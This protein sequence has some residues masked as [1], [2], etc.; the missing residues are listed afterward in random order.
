MLM[1]EVCPTGLTTCHSCTAPVLKGTLRFKLVSEVRF[2]KTVYYHLTCWKPRNL[3][4]LSADSFWYKDEKAKERVG[5]VVAWVKDWNEQFITKEETV[6]AQFLQKTV[7]TTGTPLRRL[8]LEVFQWLNTSEIETIVAVCCKAWYHVS[9]EEEFWRTR[10]VAELHPTE[11]ATEGD[12]RRKYIAYVKG[13]C[14]HCKSFLTLHEVYMRCPFF[15]RNL[16]K[17]CSNTPECQITSLNRYS[18]RQNVSMELLKELNIPTF[19]FRSK[20]GNYMLVIAA[21]VVPFIQEQKTRLLR[22]IEEL[23]G[24]AGKRAIVEKF[25]VEAYYEGRSQAFT[26]ADRLIAKCLGRKRSEKNWTSNVKGLLT[27]L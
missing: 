19:E 27:R 3:E 1:L 12:Y 13:T 9:R 18:E 7:N 22:T 17:T 5:E 25:E 16:C 20:P 24:T 14:W 6:P 21:K 2:V 23:E 10:Y 4:P 26:M 8:L 11:T 15:Q